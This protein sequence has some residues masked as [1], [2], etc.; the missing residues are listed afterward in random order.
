VKPENSRLAVDFETVVTT[1][2]RPRNGSTSLTVD[3]GVV[4]DWGA[5]ATG[6]RLAFQ[7]GG[8]ASVGVIPLVN[9]G[10][11]LGAGRKLFLEAAFPMFT[12]IEGTGRSLAAVVHTGVA[13]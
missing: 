11:E 5:V 12:G 13:F 6:L 7:V 9:R 1:P 4:Y 3:P 10:F 2:V 8:D